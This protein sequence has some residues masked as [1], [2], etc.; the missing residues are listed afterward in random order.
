MLLAPVESLAGGALVQAQ[1]DSGSPAVTLDSQVA[2]ARYQ[3]SG[4]RSWLPVTL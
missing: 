1:D 4:P 3:S 2:P